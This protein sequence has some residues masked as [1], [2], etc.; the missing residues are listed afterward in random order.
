MEG[1]GGHRLRRIGRHLTPAVFSCLCLLPAGPLAAVE[2]GLAGVFPGKA[3]L[4]IDGGEPRTVAL[5]SRTA[6]GVQVLAIDRDAVTLEVDGRKRTLRVG[7]S[8]VSQTSTSR[9][10]TAVLNVDARGHFVTMGT[11]NG[12]AIRFLVD[13]GA[14]MIS[15][16]AADARR[17]GLDPARGQAAFVDTANGRVLVS[18]IKLDSVRV[19]D[20]ALYNVDALIHSQDMPVAL[21]GM[22]FLNRLEMQRNGDTMTLKKHY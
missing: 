19:G 22:S 3:L 14:S 2:V 20:I 11:V 1:H 12:Q 21:L 8:V 18:R 10:P 5:G 13:T 9:P 4:T 17:I 16:G 15:L 6:E 7:Q